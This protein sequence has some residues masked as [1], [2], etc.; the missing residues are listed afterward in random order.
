M[1]TIFLINTHLNL[2][3]TSLKNTIIFRSI[4]LCTI[5]HLNNA[6]CFW[7]IIQKETNYCQEIITYNIIPKYFLLLYDSNELFDPEKPNKAFLQMFYDAVQS[8]DV[9]NVALLFHATFIRYLNE[10]INKD[11]ALLKY[12]AINIFGLCLKLM[13]IVDTRFLLTE[14]S[15][16]NILMYIIDSKDDDT[17]EHMHLKHLTKIILETY[18]KIL[19]GE[20][21][22]CVLDKVYDIP[23]LCNCDPQI[24][25]EFAEQIMEI[26]GDNDKEICTIIEVLM[27]HTGSIP[28]NG[29][30]INDEDDI[31]FDS[32]ENEAVDLY[33]FEEDK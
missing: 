30:A 9:K 20:Q 27:E 31:L 12:L 14:K 2:W 7:T 26:F 24:N 15:I 18:C 6:I 13:D 8:F 29:E 5:E 1:I 21:C 16:S 4:S 33:G 17:C 19:S 25:S 3:H 28:S 11:E 32:E 10:C 22:N 23:L